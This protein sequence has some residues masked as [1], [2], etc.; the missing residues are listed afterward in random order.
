[1]S[2]EIEVPNPSE[3]CCPRCAKLWETYASANRKYVGLLEE[4][5]AVT[6][7]ERARLL[8]PLIEGAEQRRKSARAAIESHRLREHGKP[9]TK[10]AP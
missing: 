6:S 9:H 10:T 1:M 8:D 2:S 4:Q 7:L 5:Q 3:H